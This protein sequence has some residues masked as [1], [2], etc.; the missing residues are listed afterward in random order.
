MD[1]GARGLSIEIVGCAVPLE[2]KVKVWQAASYTRVLYGQVSEGH[3]DLS[4]NTTGLIAQLSVTCYCNVPNVCITYIICIT[5]NA[6]IIP[7][8]GL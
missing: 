1:L 6:L 8:N 7:S 2:S 4:S 5:F 3:S